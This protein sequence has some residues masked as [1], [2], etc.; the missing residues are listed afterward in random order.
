MAT[1]FPLAESE[2]NAF[3][4]VNF[5]LIFIKLWILY[6]RTNTNKVLIWNE[7]GSWSEV[8]SS[9]T[10]VKSEVG[11]KLEVGTMLEVGRK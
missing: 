9:N 10:V 11:T 7:V 3:I 1:T 8:G 4:S 6:L 2:S 5:H